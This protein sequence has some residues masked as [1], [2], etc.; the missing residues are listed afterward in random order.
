MTNWNWQL[1]ANSDSPHTAGNI[2]QI[3]QQPHFEDLGH[4][5]HNPDLAPSD[6][7]LY[8]S[9]V[10]WESIALSVTMSW[11]RWC[12]L[13]SQKHFSVKHTKACAMPDPRCVEKQGDCAEKLS[14][15]WTLCIVLLILRS[16]LQIHLDLPL[17]LSNWTGP[18]NFNSFPRTELF[19]H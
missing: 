8:P 2:V 7:H 4:P 15:L 1:G 3:L 12:L 16:S 5:P 17:Y 6:C 9:E 19:C 10:L 13:P 14:S 18:D 11:R